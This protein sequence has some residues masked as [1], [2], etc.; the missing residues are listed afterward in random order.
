MFLLKAFNIEEVN[1][2]T[3]TLINAFNRI[4]TR[5]KFYSLRKKQKFA[6]NLQ[7]QHM[8]EKMVTGANDGSNIDNRNDSYMVYKTYSVSEYCLRKKYEK[9]MT[10]LNKY[11]KTISVTTIS[12]SI[13]LKTTDGYI[14]VKPTGKYIKL[15][16]SD[17]ISIHILLNAYENGISITN[18]NNENTGKNQEKDVVCNIFKSCGC[19]TDDNLT[20]MQQ[21]MQQYGLEGSEKCGCPVYPY[22][23]VN[24]IDIEGLIAL[25]INQK[26][27]REFIHEY[28]ICGYKGPAISESDWK[29][30]FKHVT[31]SEEILVHCFYHPVNIQ[32]TYLAVHQS[33]ISESFIE[34]HILPHFQKYDMKHYQNLFLGKLG[35]FNPSRSLFV[36]KWRHKNLNKPKCIEG[37]LKYIHSVYGDCVCCVSSN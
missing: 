15:K 28:F 12:D 3:V 4:E 24:F 8:C 36:D 11:K 13:Q 29:Q 32:L 21:Y 5:H 26:I 30:I 23:V 19:L 10:R 35:R 17:G 25:C 33:H 31:F 20:E 16:T 9:S 14:D 7:H 22:G 34:K 1:L 37:S 2:W 6:N 27:S 18:D